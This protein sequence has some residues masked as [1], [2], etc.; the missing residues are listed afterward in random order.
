MLRDSGAKLADDYPGLAVHGVVADFE[1][2]LWRLPSDG[3]RLV[4]FLG[5]TIG[6]LVPDERA[7]FLASVGAVLRPGEWLLLGTDLVKD[8]LRLVRAYDDAAGVTAQFNRNV[9]HVINRELGADFVPDKFA[10]RADLG[11]GATSGSRCG[12]GRSP[13][14]RSLSPASA[15]RSS[16]PPARSCHRD[17]RQVPA[18]GCGRRV[19]RRRLRDGRWWTDADGDFGLTLAQRI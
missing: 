16:S 7:T 4:A 10:H 12:C 11:R 9:L 2:H 14:S 13:T 1:R 19:G 17:Q 8:P 6:N 18:R 5:G 15:S 3:R